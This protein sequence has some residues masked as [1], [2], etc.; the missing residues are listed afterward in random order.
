MSC[1]VQLWEL[2]PKIIGVLT[3]PCLTSHISPVPFSLDEA[4]PPRTERMAVDQ[5]WSSVYPTAAAFKAASVPLPIR[6]GYPVKRGV[7]PP[8]GGNLELIKVR[9]GAMARLLKSLFTKDALLWLEYL[10][11]CY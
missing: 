2:I 9:Q 11:F 1:N 6:M 4:A 5:D 8:K 7:P 10:S 3:L